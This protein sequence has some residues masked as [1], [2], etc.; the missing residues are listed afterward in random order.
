MEKN[1]VYSQVIQETWS[2]LARYPNMKTTTT[3]TLKKC[4]ETFKKWSKD[5]HK[6]QGKLINSKLNMIKALNEVNDGNLNHEIRQI[7]KEIDQLLE[8]AT[9]K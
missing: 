9:R 4:Q 5:S 3:I 6:G 8:E 1:E 7:L 2:D